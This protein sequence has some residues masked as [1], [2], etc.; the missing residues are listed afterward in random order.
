MTNPPCQVQDCDKRGSFVFEAKMLRRVIQPRESE[1]YSWGE[2]SEVKE[3]KRRMVLCGD[4]AKSTPFDYVG[5][6]P[7]D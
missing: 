3:D 7:E 6:L 4:H 1:F 2:P 5:A